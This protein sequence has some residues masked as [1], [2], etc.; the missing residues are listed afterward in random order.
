MLKPAATPKESCTLP[1]ELH[2]A[3]VELRW[4]TGGLSGRVIGCATFEGARAVASDQMTLFVLLKTY[5]LTGTLEPEGDHSSK[6]DS[7]RCVHHYCGPLYDKWAPQEPRGPTVMLTTGYT[8]PLDVLHVIVS[9][10]Q[11]IAYLLHASLIITPG[12]TKLKTQPKK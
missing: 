9:P 2:V 1:S 12:E 8:E 5:I 4:P 6:P 3:L 10:L 11:L 7:S